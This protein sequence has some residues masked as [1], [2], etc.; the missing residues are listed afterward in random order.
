MTAGVPANPNVLNTTALSNFAYIDKLWLL[1][2]L[3]GICTVPVVR[4]EL[5]RGVDDHSYLRSAL[6]VLDGGIPVGTVSRRVQYR[7]TVVS[8]HLDLGEAQALRWRTYTTV[9][10]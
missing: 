8:E 10:C 3:S 5:E 9:D 2:G 6:N 7:V 4:E 1:I